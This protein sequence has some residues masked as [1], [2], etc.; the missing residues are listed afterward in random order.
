METLEIL[1]DI[2][3]DY[4]VRVNFSGFQEIVEALDGVEVYSDYSFSAGGH[5]FQQGMNHVDGTA[6]LSFVR[7]R[8]A[9]SDGDAQR[10]RNQMA[11]V[12]AIINKATSPAIL[13]NYLDLLSSL[14]S[15]FIT[16]IPR[17]TISDIVKD[18]LDEGGSWNIVSYTVAGYCGSEYC[19]AL[20]DYASVMY[21]NEEAIE[22]AKELMQ[23]VLE[24]KTI[25][26]PKAES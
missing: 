18:Q 20:G 22:T 9:F 12:Q 19:P 16:D 10:G 23:A 11:M 7:E 8:Y 25:S 3:I 5:Y 17:W 14:S 4:Y 15:C 24:G 2:D 13:T 6:A 1:Y 21:E 26:E